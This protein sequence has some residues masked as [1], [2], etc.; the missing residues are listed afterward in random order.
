MLAR[1]FV[2][3]LQGFLEI[4]RAGRPAT[5]M[6]AALTPEQVRVVQDHLNLVFVHDIDPAIQKATGVPV[7]VAQQVHDGKP[8]T[9]TPVPAQPGAGT[10][11]PFHPATSG[12]PGG[13][14]MY[15]C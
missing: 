2:Y 13:N 14:T 15:R 1:D 6:P 10:P 3:W 4:A 12:G 7:E 5:E 9:G 8:M 11:F